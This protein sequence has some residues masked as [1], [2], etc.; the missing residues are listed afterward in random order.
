MARW[1]LPGATAWDSQ[2]RRRDHRRREHRE[3]GARR[4]AQSREQTAEN[5][6]VIVD[7]AHPHRSA[8]G[9]AVVHCGGGVGLLGTTASGRG[10]DP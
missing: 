3:Q 6:R 2:G 1:G 8:M 5:R 4:L 9:R 10:D 7:R